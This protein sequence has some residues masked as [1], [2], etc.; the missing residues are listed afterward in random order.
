MNRRYFLLGSAAFVAAPAVAVEPFDAVVKD[1]DS[2][3]AAI[4]KAPGTVPYRIFVGEGSF[5]EKLQITKANVTLIGAGRDRTR[6]VFGDYAGAPQPG[7]AVRALRSSA[8][9]TVHAPDFSARD[10][11]IENDFDYVANLIK[12][13]RSYA[14]GVGLQGLA[15]SL[16]DAADRSLFDR[17]TFIGHQDTL[18]ADAGR[19]CFRDCSISGSVDFIFGGGRAWFEGCEIRSRFR[20]GF[21][22]NQGFITAPSTKR[23]QAFGLVFSNCSL[24]REAL[25]PNGSVVLGRPWRPNGDVQALGATVFLNCWMDAHISADGWDEMGYAAADGTR[26]FLQPNEAR[27]AEYASR[28]PGAFRTP[29]RRWL[30]ATEARGITRDRVLDGWS[31]ARAA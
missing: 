22:R 9:L 1:G 16:A 14:G 31:P 29:R 7:G 10:L 27:L 18:F 30:T 12:S 15:L 17:V 26:I 13:E 19:S 5:R 24:L 21:Q 8:T 25:V 23:T 11:T 28:G 4:D 6:L 20:P 2:L 3:Q